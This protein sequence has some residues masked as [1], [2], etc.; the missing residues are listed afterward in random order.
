MQPQPSQSHPIAAVGP[1]VISVAAAEIGLPL[2][3]A[4]SVQ[5]ARY[6]A[7]LLRWNKVHNLTAIDTPAQMLTHHLLDS[8]SIVPEL[9]GISGGHAVRALDVGSGGGLPGIVLAIAAPHIDVT[10]VDKVQK[11]VAF[12]T[13]AKAELGLTNLACVHSRVETWQPETRFE[14]IVSRAFASLTEFVRLTRHLIDPRGWW[15]AM[16]GVEPDAELREIERS[17]P[18]V[19]IVRTV[20]L[21]VPRLEAQR[22]LVIMQIAPH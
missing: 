10:V 16:K 14:L 3:E 9:E 5:L 4:Q 15:C 13:Q 18:D 20:K 11:K 21:H 12:L 8:L 7:L 22:H 2:H 6:G 17:I 19:R 1:E